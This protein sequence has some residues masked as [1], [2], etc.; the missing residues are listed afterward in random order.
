MRERRVKSRVPLMASAAALSLT[1][2]AC[3]GEGSAGEGDVES[4][5][6][7]F[8]SGVGENHPGQRH[9]RTWAE[10]VTE[11][12][13]GAVE[14]EYTYGGALLPIDEEIPGVG[15]GRADMAYGS[16][17]Y[18]PS[19][20]PLTTVGELPFITRN[21]EA[22]MKAAHDLLQEHEAVKAEWEA[23]GVKPLFQALIGSSLLG[24]TE[25][26]TSI[27]DL[28]GLQIRA[29]G[30]GAQSYEA[31]GANVVTIPFP[32][33]YESAQRGLVDA[34]SGLG[35]T[36]FHSGQ[37][38][39]VTPIIHDPGHGESIAFQTIVINQDLYESLTPEIKEAFD[40]ATEEYYAGVADLVTEDEEAACRAMLEDGA[41]F[42]VW[43]QAEIDKWGPLIADELQA[44]WVK[45]MDDQGLP[46]EDV[47]N[48]YLEAVEKYEAEASYV[49]AVER[50][51][52]I[53]SESSE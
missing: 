19:L 2:A 9:M 3:G 16:P 33:L 34:I 46:G 39:Q 48:T 31:A 52:Q 45:T 1:V 11:L 37:L 13:D 40:T 12:T 28:E 18:N 25:E 38:Y 20:L 5:T 14:F 47:L 42:V 10:R 4:V 53:A 44:N 51:A 8:S 23:A 30:A 17:H 36:G 7:T 35:F 49:P 43:D 32:E 26:L 22:Q 6:M 15:D 27:E 41:E 29:F 24:S 50:C 21:A